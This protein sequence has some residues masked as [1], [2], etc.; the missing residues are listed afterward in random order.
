MRTN[1]GREGDSQVADLLG[2]LLPPS[3][4]LVVIRGIDA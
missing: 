3:F 4:L 1:F 2:E